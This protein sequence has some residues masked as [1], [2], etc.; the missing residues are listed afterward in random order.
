MC[1]QQR[2][3][4]GSHVQFFETS[5]AALSTMWLLLMGLKEITHR[6]ENTS[7][8]QMAGNRAWMRCRSNAKGVTYCRSSRLLVREGG[9]VGFFLV[10]RPAVLITK[11]SVCTSLLE[12]HKHMEGRWR[13]RG[14]GCHKNVQQRFMFSSAPARETEP[15]GAG[16]SHMA[17]IRL[18]PMAMRRNGVPGRK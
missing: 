14:R 16:G 11:G 5:R 8:V 18:G 6:R 13:G 12:S 7:R 1:M 3:L 17:V 2:C 4:R 9:E 15:S 10:V